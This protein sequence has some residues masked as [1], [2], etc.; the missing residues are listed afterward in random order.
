MKGT[1][2]ESTRGAKVALY[3]PILDQY[4]ETLKEH[5]RLTSVTFCWM[6]GET[7]GQ[8]RAQAAYKDALKLLITKLRRDLQR[9]DMNIVIGRISGLWHR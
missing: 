9:P 3:Q 4:Q 1:Y 7:D 5:P 6:Q 2:R 8:A